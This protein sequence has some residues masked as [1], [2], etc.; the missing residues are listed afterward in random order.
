M[1]HVYE[2]REVECAANDREDF[3]EPVPHFL[4]HAVLA[5]DGVDVVDKLAELLIHLSHI[6]TDFRRLNLDLSGEYP[7]VIRFTA[8]GVVP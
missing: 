6:R 4:L 5:L 2:V 1:E 8:F 7:K 3:A